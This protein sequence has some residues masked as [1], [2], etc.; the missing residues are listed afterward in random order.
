MSAGFFDVPLASYLQKK[1]P[2]EKR[3]AI[4]SATNC[5]GFGGVAVVSLIFGMVLRQDSSVGDV[6][7][8]PAAYVSS[9]LDA[10]SKASVDELTD[11]LGESLA[12]AKPNDDE[13]KSFAMFSEIPAD[14][15]A[16]NRSALITNLIRNDMQRQVDAGEMAPD[17][18]KYKQLFPNDMKQVNVVTRN[19]AKQPWFSAKQIFV[20]LGLLT[21]PVIAYAAWRVP[22]QMAR[23]GFWMLYKTLF[24]I[25]VRGLENLPEKGGAILVFN[26]VSWMDGCTILTLIPEPLRTIAWGGNFKNSLAKK[27]ADFCGVILI[28]GGPKSIRRGLE[29]AG[30]ALKNGEMVAIFGEGGN[31]RSEMVRTIKPGVMKMLEKNNVPVIPCYIGEMW[32]SIFSY[33]GGRVFT[34]FPN[35]IRRPV[36]LHVGKPIFPKSTFEIQ[37]AL[38]RLSAESVEHYAGCLLY[39]SP[40]PRDRG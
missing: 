26:H 8:L 10:E 37:D 35:S 12:M 5:L 3:G 22:R 7:S 38:K 24:R 6:A 15:D 16:K 29:T 34:K 18:K 11:S 2:I 4:L 19:A 25:K 36:S 17:P 1:S 32:G 31:S 21:I 20:L 13:M 14:M 39:T 23:V 27:W 30:E 9:S 28:S 33:F 40:S